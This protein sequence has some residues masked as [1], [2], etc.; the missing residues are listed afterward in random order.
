MKGRDSMI[1]VCGKSLEGLEGKTITEMLSE[2]GYKTTYIAV[3]MNGEI[4]KR[5]N[6][7]S[8]I[9]KE[10]DKLEVVNFVGGG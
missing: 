8:T 9:L 10:N 2:L 3:E 6:Y 4:L 1:T 7:A 5:D